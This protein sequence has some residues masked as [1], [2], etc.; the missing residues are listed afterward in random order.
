[1]YDLDPIA[2]FYWNQPRYKNVMH[3]LCLKKDFDLF[4]D[5]LLIIRP[6][7]KA[8]DVL[9][10]CEKDSEEENIATLAI[11]NFSELREKSKFLFEVTAD[12][13]T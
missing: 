5:V 4:M 7:I 11:S 10:Y 1:M 6:E 12:Y 2:E 8:E 13:C 9:K 3:Y